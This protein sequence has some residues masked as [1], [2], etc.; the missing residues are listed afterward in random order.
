MK[1]RQRFHLWLSG[2]PL[3]RMLLHLLA[4]WGSRD[5]RAHLRGMA[6]ELREWRRR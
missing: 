1:R 3:G 2:H 6:R 5:R 4:L